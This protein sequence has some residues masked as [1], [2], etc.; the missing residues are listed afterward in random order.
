MQALTDLAAVRAKQRGTNFLAERRD[1]FETRRLIADLQ[2]VEGELQTA[3][4]RV[5]R[6]LFSLRARIVAETMPVTDE[7]RERARKVFAAARARFA[8]TERQQA[9][10]EQQ[11]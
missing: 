3:A 6:E 10:S 4:Q 1:V 11:P 2:S 5:F 9:A 7:L 8:E